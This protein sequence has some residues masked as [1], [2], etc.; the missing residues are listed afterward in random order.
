MK[1]VVYLCHPVGAESV[2]GI[3]ANLARARRWLKALV[4]ATDWSIVVSWMPYVEALD[5]AGYRERGL[6]DDLA[7]IERCNGVVLV[8]G[9]VSSGMALERDHA[10]AV[11]LPVFDLTGLGDEPPSTFLL[12]DHI[13]RV[14][15]A[16]EMA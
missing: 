9:R 14:V 11:N 15:D 4:D 8:G 12:R 10:L 1:K 2:V 13:E 16:V 6:A 7:V 3:N 5:E